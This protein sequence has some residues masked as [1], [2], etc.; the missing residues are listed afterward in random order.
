MTVP[1]SQYFDVVYGVDLEL[2]HLTQDSN[3]INFV[4]RTSVNNGVVAKVKIIP[5][6][7]P[8]PSHTISVAGSG[9]VMES[10]LQNEPY[11]SGRDLFYLKP[12]I[13]LTDK[14]LL[15]Y[16]MCLK[17]NKYKFNYGRQADLTPVNNAS[18]S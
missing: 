2:V 7:K 4:A 15:F 3:G 18:A 8:N 9:S 6:I 16:C 17:A 5:D 11:Y 13:E 10:F 1:V 14:Q 12:K